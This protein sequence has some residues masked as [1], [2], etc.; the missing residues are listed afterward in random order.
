VTSRAGADRSV[1]A[2]RGC[3]SLFGGKVRLFTADCLHA[4]LRHASLAAVATRGIR[5]ISDYLSPAISLEADYDRI[6]ELERKLGRR[7]EFA[8]VAR[9]VQLLVR[10]SGPEPE[11]SL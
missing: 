3:E 9:Y 5:V 7:P 4:M 6:L 2:E 1:T 10:R 8:A 11:R